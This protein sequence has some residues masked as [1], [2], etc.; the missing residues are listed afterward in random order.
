MRT[1]VTGYFRCALVPYG[2][3]TGRCDEA[4]DVILHWT[5]LKQLVA[6][7]FAAADDSPPATNDP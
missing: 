7:L 5:W 2:L 6:H 3:W 1:G 4:Y